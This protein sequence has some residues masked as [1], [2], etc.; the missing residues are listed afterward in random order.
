MRARTASRIRVVRAA[1][2]AVDCRVRKEA[3]VYVG[4]DLHK[5]FLQVAAIDKSGKILLEE[6]VANDRNK[7]RRFL[8]RFPKRTRYVLEDP[9]SRRASP[10][11]CWT[12]S[13]WIW[14]CPA[15]STTR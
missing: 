10:S 6:K 9:P 12:T 1:G 13:A 4:I 3:D 8:A 2:T 15:R 7:I 14:S 5:A 11:S